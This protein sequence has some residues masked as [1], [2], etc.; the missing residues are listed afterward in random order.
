MNWTPLLKAEIEVTYST[1]AKLIEKVDPARLDWKP[2]SGS[3][4]MSTGQLLKHL[5]CACG[6]GCKAFL[7]DDWGMPE[8]KKVEDLSPEEMLPPAEKLPTMDSVEEALKLLAEDKA[9]AL[10]MIDQA[11][12]LDLAIKQVAAPWAP[13][14]KY[15][16]GRHFLQMIQHLDRHKAQL[17]F[18]LKLQGKP[19]GTV[20]LW[21]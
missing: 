1:T 19:V 9:L 21:G 18:Y 14:V 5:T 12:E 10:Q 15:P 7:T 4:G 11:G 17:F 6:A 3:N 13:G 20:D 16:L 8:G 2:A